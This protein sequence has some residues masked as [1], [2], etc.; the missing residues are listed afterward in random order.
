MT[1][2]IKGKQ[3]TP[4]LSSKSFIVLLPLLRSLIHFELIIIILKDLF[5]LEREREREGGAK[6]E[7]EK[8]FLSR[9]PAECG[10]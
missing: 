7:G 2:N 4:I 5:I 1:P 10:A 9:L 8:E 6:R 3:F